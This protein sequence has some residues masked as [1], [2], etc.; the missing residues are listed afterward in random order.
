MSNGMKGPIAIIDDDALVQQ[1]LRDC[2][3]SAGFSV[4]SFD[5]AEDFLASDSTEDPRCLIVDVQLP[6]ISGFELQ[7]RLAVADNRVPMVFVTGHGTN[8]NR[9]RAIQHGAAGSLSKPVRREALLNAVEA[10]IER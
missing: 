2:M 7:G 1:S 4:L 10:A 8:A 3:E 5:S 9:E 6:G